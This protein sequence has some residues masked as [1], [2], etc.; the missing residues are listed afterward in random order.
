MILRHEQR[1]QTGLW[2][3]MSVIQ[4]TAETAS[5]AKDCSAINQ[6]NYNFTV[7][8]VCAF[9]YIFRWLF[10][11]RRKIPF[12]LVFVCAKV[13]LSIICYTEW[14]SACLVGFWIELNVGVC[15]NSPLVHSYVLGFLVFWSIEK[16]DLHVFSSIS[17]WK[18]SSE[19]VSC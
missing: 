8:K 5:I 18:L 1:V 12:S 6:L 4:H 14:I 10:L 17:L 15:Y 7:G 19:R 2:R 13:D 16:C 9:V 11:M 3:M